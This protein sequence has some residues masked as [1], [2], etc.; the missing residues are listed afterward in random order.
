MQL[1]S[2]GA[3]KEAGCNYSLPSN[4]KRKLLILFHSKKI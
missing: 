1:Q 2:P 3:L 4:V